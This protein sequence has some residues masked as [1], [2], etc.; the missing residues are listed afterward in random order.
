MVVDMITFGGPAE[1]A[2]I[3]FDWTVTRIELPNERMPKEIFYLPAMLLM[4]LVAWVQRRRHQRDA[5]V[6]A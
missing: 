3:D 5:E 2:G 1:Q 6:T 4:A